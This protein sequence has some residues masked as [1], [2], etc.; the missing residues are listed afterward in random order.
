MCIV[1]ELESNVNTMEELDDF[2]C[3]GNVD[4]VTTTMP[5]TGSI[6]V[7]RSDTFQNTL[8]LT[9]GVKSLQEA[10]WI[11]NLSDLSMPWL[12]PS[13]SW[14]S[15]SQSLTMTE[16]ASTFGFCWDYDDS[17]DPFTTLLKE[18]L[19]LDGWDCGSVL[20]LC[21][22]SNSST[23]RLVSTFLRLCPSSILLVSEWC[24]L[25]LPSRAG[26][27][28]STRWR[29]RPSH[30]QPPRCCTTQIGRTTCGAWKSS[31]V[32]LIASTRT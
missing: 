22:A 1:P 20:D 9:Y 2:L 18:E 10:V 15:L 23:V 12:A 25:W 27:R 4:F 30:V 3:A 11:Q 29:S 17:G 16:Y 19:G 21:G 31:L 7:E 14:F 24:R 13:D 8:A 32:R 6:V 28:S 26:M 5:S